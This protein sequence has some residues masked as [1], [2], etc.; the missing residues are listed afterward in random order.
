MLAYAF[1][2]LQQGEY[3]DV[4][5]EDFE[6]IHDLFAAILVKGVGRQLKQGLLL[7][8]CQLVVEGMLITTES[9]EHRLAQ[10]IDDQRLH[11]LYEK[12][13]LEYYAQE[14]NELEARASQIPWALDDGMGTLLPVMQSDITL[15][16]KRDPGCVLIIDAKFYAHATQGQYGSRTVHSANLY[17]IFTYVKNCEAG[18]G[19]RPHEVGG[20]L[21][22]AR[23]NEAVQPNQSYKM[24]GSRIEVRTLDL[25][26]EF[27]E[28]A[29]QLDGIAVEYF[30]AKA[31]VER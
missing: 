20:M 22:Y 7:S 31:D 19:E 9:G 2:A 4:S 26:Q 13:I 8:I 30:M 25:N 29:A 23:T 17:Q 28:I 10:F 27:V 5:T 11:R 18:F 1:Q 21:L 24:S 12:F 3:T 6:H 14:H 16:D 15:T